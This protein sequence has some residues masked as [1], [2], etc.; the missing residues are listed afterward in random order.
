M[1]R[2]LFIILGFSSAM[3]F[4]QNEAN[5]AKAIEEFIQSFDTAWNS[6]NPKALASLWK[7]DGDLMTF[8]GRWMMGQSQ[9]EK[10]FEQEKTG[11]FGKSTIQQS[12]DSKRFLTPQIVFIDATI[13]INNIDDPSGNIPSNL[14]EHGTYLLT[15]INNRWK[16]LALR[17]Y[18]FQAHEVN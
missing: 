18:Q 1:F 17:M 3:I 6:H 9:I 2:F 14:V 13:K 8:W 15:K 11:P 12:I 5:D 4:A 16:I 10:H 7:E